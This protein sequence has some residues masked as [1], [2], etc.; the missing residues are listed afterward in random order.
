MTPDDTSK[1]EEK[2][3]EDASGILAAS[4]RAAAKQA[5]VEMLREEEK[6]RENPHEAD[7]LR[8]VRIE[9]MFFCCIVSATHTLTLLTMILIL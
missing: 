1:L 6:E 9:Q 4:A 7:I 8:E 2:R 3:R 5:E